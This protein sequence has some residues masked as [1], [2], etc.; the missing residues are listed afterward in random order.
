L[1]DVQGLSR[2]ILLQYNTTRELPLIGSSS[3]LST[4]KECKGSSDPLCGKCDELLQQFHRFDEGIGIEGKWS[5]GSVTGVCRGW[6]STK[7]RIEFAD[8][9]KLAIMSMSNIAF[10]ISLYLLSLFIQ[11][12][13]RI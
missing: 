10:G 1:E 8:I 2:D 4:E 6:G 12:L 11:S 9:S 3:I 5:G 13:Q 7:V